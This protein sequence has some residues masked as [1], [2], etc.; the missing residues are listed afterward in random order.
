MTTPPGADTERLLQSSIAAANGTV[1]TGSQAAAQGE[2]DG[3]KRA[4]RQDL[5]DTLDLVLFASFLQVSRVFEYDALKLNGYANYRSIA[6]LY[7]P[8][9]G[10]INRQMYL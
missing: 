8:Q 4:Q 1:N 7:R 6:F 3:R 10:F 2:G 5:L 9:L